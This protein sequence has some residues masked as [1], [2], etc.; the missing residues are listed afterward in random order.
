MHFLLR[1]HK[2]I[3]LKRQV[4]EGSELSDTDQ[5]QV[6]KY[7]VVSRK[8]RGGKSQVQFNEKAIREARKK[9]GYFVLRT[10]PK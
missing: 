7:L 4:E 2:I 6:R 1:L 9:Y 3:E 10:I 5:K 8:G